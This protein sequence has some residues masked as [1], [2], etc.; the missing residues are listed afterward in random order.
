MGR[1]LRTKAGTNP[2]GSVRFARMLQPAPAK[3]SLLSI[4]VCFLPVAWAIAGDLSS[5]GERHLVLVALLSFRLRPI[6]GHAQMRM[7]LLCVARDSQQ[8]V[9]V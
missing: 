6:L 7:N 3:L 9:K 5:G 1:G 8:L 4:C 2:S